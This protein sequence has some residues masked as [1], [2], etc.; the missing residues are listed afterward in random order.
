MVLFIKQSKYFLLVISLLFAL[1][2]R[3][4]TIEQVVD[5][6]NKQFEQ[7]NYAIASKEYNRAF[8]F[9]YEPRD[10][11]SMRIA[12]CYANTGQ[13]QMAGEFY[14]RTYRFAVTDSMRNEAVLG[15]AFSLI[16][17]K[18]FMLAINELFN[19]SDSTTHEQKIHYHFL[20]GI[21]HYGIEQ[22]T[23]SWHEFSEV[24]QLVQLNKP[25]FEALAAE[26]ENVFHFEKQFNP[27]RAYIYSGIIPGSGQFSAEAYREG[28][29]S[30]LLLGTLYALSV[31]LMFVYSFWDAAITFFPWIQRYYLGGMDRA[32]ELAHKKIEEKRAESYQTI[33]EL[34][35][36]NNF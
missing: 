36:P 15:K 10:E 24:A 21:S 17:Q 27:R 5:F 3:A 7:R 29:N 11:I 35:R 13:H 33:I 31:R 19:I 4:Q 16:I 34:T 20:K 22:D 26:F 8:Y 18:N 14:D 23:L 25:E 6:A 12:Q 32:R 9:G 28:I 1:N 30:F 2:A